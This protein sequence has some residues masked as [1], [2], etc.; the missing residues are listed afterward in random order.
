MG[1]RVGLVG[2]DVDGLAVGALVESVGFNVGD[3]V[4]R[5]GV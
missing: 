3:L 2:S 5:V 4:G 1:D